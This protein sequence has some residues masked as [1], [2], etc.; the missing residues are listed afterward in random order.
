MTDQITYTFAADTAELEEKREIS[1]LAAPYGETIT[2]NG[3]K[4]RFEKGMFA[5]AEEAHLYFN[6]EDGLPIG[7]VFHFEDT[8]EGLRIKARIA[9]TAKGNDVYALLQDGSL[10]KFS[11]GFIGQQFRQ[12]DD[13]TVWEKVDLHEVSVVP[14][15]AF[16]SAAIAEVHSA[17]T[18]TETEIDDFNMNEE[19]TNKVAELE[20]SFSD[21]ERKVAL[22]GTSTPAV[23]QNY[24]NGGE[25]LKGLAAGKEDA[26]QAFAYTGATS[27]DAD[28]IRP[29]WL[30]RGLKLV[31]ENRNVLNLFGRAALPTTGNSIEYPVV[32]GVSGTVGVQGNEGDDLPYMEVTIDTATAPV[33]TYGGYSSISRQAIERSDVAYLQTV[34]DF[35]ARQY[36]KVTNAAV[37]TALTGATGVNTG[38]L[39]VDNAGA[40][41]DTVVD[42]AALIEDNSKGSNAEF[43]LMGRGVFKR[44]AHMVDTTGRPL[45]A[46]N[47]DGANTIGSV[48]VRGVVGNIAGLP[49]VVDPALT[50]NN[51]FVASS[52]ALVSFES[53]GAPFRLQDENI[54]NLTKDF[55]LY[56][57]MAIAV[58]N[59][60]AVVKVNATLAA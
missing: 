5:G 25:L 27:T 59:P 54:I 24:S 40:W 48:N 19:I 2:H 17:D 3:R 37:R 43:V 51:V 47:A 30:N 49:I 8:D 11:V 33:K 57:Y 34:L 12:D 31:D 42:S 13:V 7:K 38:T 45:F 20:E 58:V 1:G 39:T 52:D 28:V 32:S 18:T 60:L 9:K 26:K 46:L 55:S 36:A 16:K 53:A 29:A 44:L 21:L 22:F 14:R 23:T 56:G 10:D 41:I 15:P 50:G 35:Q 6:H 4:V